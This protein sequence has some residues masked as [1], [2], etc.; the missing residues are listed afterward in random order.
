MRMPRDRDF[1]RP[2]ASWGA[3]H[4]RVRTYEDLPGTE[5]WLYERP[6]GTPLAMVFGGKR[7]KPDWHQKFGTAERR[8]RAIANY[9]DGE[10]A[11]VA[12]QAERRAK[13]NA[14]HEFEPGQLFVESW[15]YDQTNIDFYKLEKTRGKTMGYIVPIGSKTVSSKPPCERVVPD[16][17]RVREFDVL[18]GVD[19]GDEEKGRWKRLRRDGFT[20]SKGHFATPTD[21]ETDYY[22]TSFGWGH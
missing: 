7:S 12:S 21:G 4:I 6:P 15:G 8:E 10:R 14:P 1:Y 9:L 11:R 20:V 17:E 22:E 3:A 2:R 16:P 18:L 19:R 5:V 13:L